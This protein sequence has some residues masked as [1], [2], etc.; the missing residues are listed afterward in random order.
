MKRMTKTQKQIKKSLSKED[1]Q[2]VNEQAAQLKKE[3]KKGPPREDSRISWQGANKRVW[4]NHY[5]TGGKAIAY[6]KPCDLLM[7]D[8]GGHYGKDYCDPKCL[9]ILT[10]LTTGAANVMEYQKT[11][12][13]KAAYAKDLQTLIDIMTVASE[14]GR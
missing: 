13:G 12:K 2:R 7:V 9:Y 5:N 14:T 6:M 3:K 4:L 1:L 8:V 10:M 11:E